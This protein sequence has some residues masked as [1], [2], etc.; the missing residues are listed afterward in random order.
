MQRHTFEQKLHAVQAEVLVLG[1]L[2]DAALGAAVEA[3]IRGDLPGAQRLMAEAC[4]IAGKRSALETEALSQI[5]TQQ[6]VASDLRIPVAVLEVIAEL[7]RMGSYAASIAQM[8]LHLAGQPLP[9]PFP[10]IIPQMGAEVRQMLRRALLALAQRDTHQ[11]RA[12]PA[13]DDTVDHLYQ[14][15]CQAL[16]TMIKTHPA[17]MHQATYLSRVAHNLERTADRVVNICE[18]VV[19]AVTGEMKEL[20]RGEA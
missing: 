7:E 19:F 1:H 5:A 20:N 4:L 3:L 6:P 9:D 15:V 17:Q 11:A 8:T 18:W 12:I 13:Q 2:V 16:A 10:R 14:E